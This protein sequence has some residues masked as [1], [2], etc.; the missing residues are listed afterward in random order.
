MNVFAKREIRLCYIL[1]NNNG[2]YL[3]S[4][5]RGLTNTLGMQLTKSHSTWTVKTLTSGMSYMNH[6]TFLHAADIH[7]DSPLLSL[8]LPEPSQADRVRRACR[9]AFEN[10]VNTAIARKVAFVVLAGDLYDRDAPNMQV[11]VF[12]RT[13][14]ARLETQGI[15]VI[16]IKGNHDADNRITS[17]LALPGNTHV[18]SDRKPETVIYDHLPFP[19]AIHGQSFKPGPIT[20]N[21]A[22]NYP[23]PIPEAFNIGV[24]HTSLAGNPVH[25]PYA[26]CKL[27]DLT[28]KGYDYWALGHIHKST[29]LFQD[30]W[31][32]YPGNLQGRDARETGP[33]GCVLVTVEDGRVQNVEE[34]DLA[35]V[36][37]HAA[38]IDLTG[39]SDE[40]Q[41][42]GRLRKGLAEAA[43]D[44]DG[45]PT[46]VRLRLFGATVL[47]DLIEGRPQ[48]LLQTA[49]ELAGEIAGDD[50]WIEKIANDTTPVESATIASTDTTTDLYPILD[51]I[52]AE[53]GALAEALGM[54]LAALRTKLPEDLKALDA[55]R[56]L[57]DPTALNEALHK[58]K[59]RLRARLA[60]EDGT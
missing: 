1:C 21:L 29:V 48:R 7:L 59:P 52:A 30:P 14:L 32:V 53:P 12:L 49:L 50:L 51:E 11:A 27:E 3:F 2:Q 56:P 15:R 40:A 5:Q 23:S 17:G 8:V 43:Q 38:E 55:F 58:L 37:W 19:V 10:L 36:R 18:L 25:D 16:I 34:L 28:T 54:E 45:R 57:D 9:D 39:A 60:G 47:F 4:A 20:E 13:Q 35:V 44:A 24:L 42:V 41:L 26:P 31:I 6:F 22:V 46:A 33:K